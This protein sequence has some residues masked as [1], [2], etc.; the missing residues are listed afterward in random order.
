MESVYV[1]VAVEADSARNIYESL[2]KHLI[3]LMDTD[4]TRNNYE[5]LN[6]STV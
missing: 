1:A 4:S 6:K 2:I 5:S 3:K